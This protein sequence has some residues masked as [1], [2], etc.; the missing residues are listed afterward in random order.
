MR[1]RND[2]SRGE[3]H[4]ALGPFALWLLMLLAVV[5][6]MTCGTLPNRHCRSYQKLFLF[7]AVLNVWTGGYGS[8]VR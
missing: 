3:M 5:V 6:V 1:T 8:A 7:V 4:W 2:I